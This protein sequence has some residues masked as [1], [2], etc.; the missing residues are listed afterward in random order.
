[1]LTSLDTA[2]VHETPNAVMRTLAAP[3]Q[4][5]TEIAVWEVSMKAGQ[6]GP[7]H[8]ASREQVWTVLEGELQVRVG[9]ASS[10]VRASSALR[11]PAEEVRQISATTDSRVLVA[12]R[13]GCLVRTSA[14]DER[15]LPW[16]T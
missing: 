12:S 13:T 1:M 16:A 4:G 7:E 3:S 2:P 15:P 8:T 14:A 5:S 9:D 6:E 10:S 11:I